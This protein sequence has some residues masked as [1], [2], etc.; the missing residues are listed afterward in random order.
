MR[1]SVARSSSVGITF[2]TPVIDDV[3]TR[4]SGDHAAVALVGDQRH[5]AGLGDQEVAAG[6]AHVGREKMLAQHLARLARHLP[7]V[8]LARLPVHALEQ[9]GHLLL[10]LVDGRGDDVR[11]RSL[12]LICRM[13]SP[14]SVSTGCTPAASSAAFRPASSESMDFD[15]MAFFT[16]WRR[17]ISVTRRQISAPSRAHSTCPPR[18]VASVSKRSSHRSRSATQVSRMAS[19]P[20]ASPRG[21]SPPRRAGAP[22]RTAPW[23]CSAWPAAHGRRRR[24]MRAP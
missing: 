16:P 19:T 18:R 17:A 22:R 11:G 20:R 3:H 14:R 5:R 13:Y 1:I 15:L 24:R 4:Q 6:D 10:G 2:S 8:G 21:R 12:P 7:D 9:L 23:P